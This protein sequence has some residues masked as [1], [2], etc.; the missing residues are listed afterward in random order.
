MRLLVAADVHANLAALEAVLDAARHERADGWLWL[1]DLV[2][3]NAEPAA[4]VHL[5]RALGGTIVAGNHDR[6]VCQGAPG[7]GTGSAA[8]LA[9]EWTRAQL[10]SRDLAWLEALPSLALGPRFVAAHGSYLSD[11]YVSGYVTSTMLDDN[12]RAIAARPG[13]PRI[14][15][16]GH[17]HAPMLGW[18]AGDSVEERKLDRPESWP[19]GATVLVNPGAVGQPRD[20]D[21]RAAF[22]IVDLDARRVEVRRVAYDIGRACRALSAAGLPE[23][24]G[25]RLREGR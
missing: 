25:E 11:V 17:T 1:G 5:V 10:D 24:L 16:C 19:Q 8:R 23:A 15:F 21:P 22:A 9:Q 4:C 7:R 14:A 2:G 18:L 20:G 12:L 3:Y 6:D 13:W